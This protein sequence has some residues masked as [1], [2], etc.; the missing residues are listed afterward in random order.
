M[1]M[2]RS[3]RSMTR[4]WRRWSATT[5]SADKA[6][7]AANCGVAEHQGPSA[8]R[9][10]RPAAAVVREAVSFPADEAHLLAG[11]LARRLN[12]QIVRV[13]GMLPGGA[14]QEYGFT[15]ECG[16]GETVTLSLSRLVEDGAWVAGHK[17]S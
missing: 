7:E 11:G 9:G 14:E 17:P 6:R 12:E 8:I 16:C 10:H 2:M 13:A 1:S 4:P 5:R 3:R 15:C